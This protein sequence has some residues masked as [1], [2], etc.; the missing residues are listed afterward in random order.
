MRFNSNL[1][2]IY[3]NDK[4]EKI[5]LKS[6]EINIKLNNGQVLTISPDRDGSGIIVSDQSC[7]PNDYAII[8]IKLGACNLV[9]I[10]SQKIGQNVTN[11]NDE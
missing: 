8:S 3:L 5:T 4:N 9:S 6:K 11:N 1:S 2:I 7:T 10:T